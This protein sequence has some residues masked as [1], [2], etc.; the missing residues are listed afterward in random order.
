VK[1]VVWT[2]IKADVLWM[3]MM[4]PLY[5]AATVGSVLWKARQDRRLALASPHWARRRQT[6]GEKW[7]LAQ[8]R[9]RRRLERRS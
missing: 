5:L 1:I 8:M 3:L 9:Q 6:P 4:L 2:V 7:K